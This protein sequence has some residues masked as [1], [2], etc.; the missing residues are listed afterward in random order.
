M[1][2]TRTTST[3]GSEAR[4]EAREGKGILHEEVKRELGL[5]P[6]DHWTSPG[7]GSAPKS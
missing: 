2:A 5:D 3:V 6:W 4:R 1:N 7:D